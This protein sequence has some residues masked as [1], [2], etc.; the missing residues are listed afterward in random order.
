MSGRR[1]KGDPILEMK[2]LMVGPTNAN[3]ANA[4]A[5][6]YCN[7]WKII[8]WSLRLVKQTTT[9]LLLREYALLVHHSR[10]KL[11]NTAVTSGCPVVFFSGNSGDGQPTLAV[12]NRSPHATSSS[13]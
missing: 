13:L 9:H 5:Y 4:T 8:A 11:W 7:T 1:K 10:I 3:M 12:R 2:N 6:S